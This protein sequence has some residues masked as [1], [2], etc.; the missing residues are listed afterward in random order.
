MI[1]Q[2]AALPPVPPFPASLG[3]ELMAPASELLA[4]ASTFVV[5]RC[6]FR[7]TQYPC[8]HATAS[9]TLLQS[10]TFEQRSQLLEL[11]SSGSVECPQP[12][13]SSK[14]K[15]TALIDILIPFML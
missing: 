13:A 12:N 5:T 9:A 6:P 1:A 15:H 10:L 4:P 11:D 14:T 2:I 3:N 7:S 8:S